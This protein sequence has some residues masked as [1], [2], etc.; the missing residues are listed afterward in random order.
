MTDD[1][2][3]LLNGGATKDEVRYSSDV[4]YIEEIMD[5][6]EVYPTMQELKL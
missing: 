1:E 6:M 4:Y 2:L 3:M 5:V